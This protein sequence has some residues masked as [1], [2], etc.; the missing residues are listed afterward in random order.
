MKIMKK[1]NV[2]LI[3]FLFLIINI[4][5]D[6]LK[7]DYNRPKYENPIKVAV[8]GDVS[9]L[10]ESVENIF[11]GAQLAS[12]EI[13]QKGGLEINGEKREVELIFK[14]SAGSPETGVEIVQELKNQGIDIVIGPTFSSVAVEM[15]EACVEYNMLM[16]TYS[17]TTPELTFLNDN[18]LI[19]R[20][21]PSDY[22]FGT[23]SAGYCYDS[24]ELNKAA[25]LYRDDRF[26]SGLSNIIFENFTELGGT[27]TATVNFPVDEINLSD[28][29]FDY[30][31][32]TVFRQRIDVLYI[33]AFNSEISV[34][35]NKI[36]NNAKYQSLAIKPFFFV[37]EGILAEEIL[38]NGNPELLDDVLGIT[39]TNK[40]NPN[41]AKYKNNYQTRFGFSPAPYS[42]QAYDAVY[43]IAYAMQRGNTTNPLII[44]EY[45][46]EISGEEYYQQT[47]EVI[48]INVNEF[49][50]GR[51]IL[52]KGKPINYEGATGPINF[53]MNGD[54]VPKI[55]IWGF[56]NKEY[57]ELSYYGNNL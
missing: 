43:C 3:I 6:N 24:L 15:A 4:S 8:V 25:I 21:C 28:Y 39:S 20:T 30:Q 49:D 38:T 53:D 12:E 37:N 1:Y 27:I 48:K 9:V 7:E 42:E 56:E 36:Y 26:G 41:Y 29:N 23:I 35:T 40:G 16:M 55:V 52:L 57:V 46:Q 2:F 32:N 45:L 13:N 10:R 22:T 47:D 50:I 5:C 44:K 11:F 17:A 33:V 54:P 51:N 14:N 31:M 34:I 19:W 18:N